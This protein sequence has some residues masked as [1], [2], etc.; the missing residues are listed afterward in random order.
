MDFKDSVRTS[1]GIADFL[2]QRYLEDLT[3]QE[4]LVRPAPDANH[5]AWQLGHL[6]QSERHLVE[7][8]VPGSMPELPAGFAERHTTDTATSENPADFLSKEEYLKIAKEIR[9]GTLKALDSLS[10]A[11]FDKPV[12][13]RVPPVVKRAGDAFVMNG[14]HWASHTGQWVVTRRKLGRPRMF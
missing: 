12:T 8:A 9:A 4:M 11:D 13:G 14:I 7:A 2:V 5:V 6:I 10:E 3:P 1:L